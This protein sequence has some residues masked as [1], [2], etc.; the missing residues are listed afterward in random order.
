MNTTHRYLIVWAACAGLVGSAEALAQADNEWVGAA[1]S[2]NG[3][4]VAGNWSAGGPPDP[5]L[6]DNAKLG[7]D[8]GIPTVPT[9]I[10]VTITTNLSSTPSP[11]VILGDASGYQG[12]LNLQSGAQFVTSTG[13]QATSANFDVGIDGGVGFLNVSGTAR[14]EVG[15]Q[16]ATVPSGDPSSTITLLDSANVTAGAL[17]NEHNMRVVGPNVSLSVTGNAILGG[18]GTHEW[19]FPLSGATSGPSVLYVG[20]QLSLDGTLKIDTQ[21]ETPA[22]GDSFVIAD[23][24]SVIQR[25][26]GIDTSDIT[27]FDGLGQ[28]VAARV[29]SASDVSS[30]NGILTRLVIEQQPVLSVHRRTGEVSIRNPSTSHATVEFDAYVVGSADGSL[31]A[32]NWSSIAPASGWQQANPTAA[33]ISELNPLSSQ[34]LMTDADNSL[35]AIFQP[36]DKPFG[37]NTDDVT[38]RFAPNGEEFVDGIVVYEGIP[39]DTL[40]LNVDRTN[41]AAQILNGFREAVSID[42]YVIR[43]TSESLDTSGFAPIGG[44]WQVALNATDV[45]SELNPL[46]TLALSANQGQSL[47]NLYDYGK[48][49]AAEDLVFQFSLP[50]E[51]F[52]RTGKVVFDD[53]LTDLQTGLSGD[54]N[55]DGIVNLADYAVWRNN[56]GAPEAVLPPGTGNNSGVVDSGDYDLWKTHFGATASSAVAVSSAAVPE[57]AAVVLL[58]MAFGIIGYMASHRSR[59]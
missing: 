29:I 38:F 8:T 5:N 49:G 47:G 22:I 6:D 50:T 30:T 33:A 9:S 13:G 35:G 3:W 1:S 34:S 12:T 42:S 2:L 53:E 15:G 52:F 36:A 54:F 17:F 59:R 26:T 51:D 28:G 46:T 7:A 32:S 55:G 40:T 25:F 37:E 48:V 20:G 23:S 57:P 58:G 24:Q 18:P 4:N 21:G 31:N 41:G 39:T 27:G 16:L 19:E 10:E 43:S 44:N 45:V 56:L 11:R 14:L